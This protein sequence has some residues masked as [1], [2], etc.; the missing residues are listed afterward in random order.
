MLKRKEVNMK[1]ANNTFK[2]K[3]KGTGSKVYCLLHLLL[4][5]LTIGD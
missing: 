2:L 3:I 1:K 4:N 5:P